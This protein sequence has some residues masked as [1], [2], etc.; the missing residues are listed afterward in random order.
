V[1]LLVGY[2][3]AF[4]KGK[5]REQDTLCVELYPSLCTRGHQLRGRIIPRDFN[6]MQSNAMDW[7]DGRCLL[8][9]QRA[10]GV[11]RGALLLLISR[12]FLSTVME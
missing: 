5:V 2:Y 12:L 8:T 11:V 9:T 7:V 6:G 4:Q 1:V 10:V 3:T